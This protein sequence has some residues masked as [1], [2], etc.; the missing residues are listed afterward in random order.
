MQ[1]KS[2]AIIH[3]SHWVFRA[4]SNNL[5]KL[6]ILKGSGKSTRKNRKIKS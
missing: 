4:I 3:H 2:K 1:K 6:F 5:R